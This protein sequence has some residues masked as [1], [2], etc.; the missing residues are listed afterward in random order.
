MTFYYLLRLALYPL[1]CFLCLF[2]KKIRKRFVFERAINQKLG[3]LA[4]GNFDTAFEFSSE[5]E[6]ELVKPL[7]QYSL[8]RGDKIELLFSSDSV[9]GAVEKLQRAYP[10]QIRVL[11]LPIVSFTPFGRSFVKNWVSAKRFVLTRYDFFP[12]IIDCAKNKEFILISGSLKKFIANPSKLKKIYFKWVYSSFDKI[13]MATD[14]EK[15]NVRTLGI[16]H[17]NIKSFDFRPFQIFSRINQ[18]EKNDVLKKVVENLN[19]DKRKKII[20]G[21]FWADE[22][23][24]LQNP[25]PDFFDQFQVCV[26]PHLLDSKSIDECY[27][28]LE[29]IFATEISIFSKDK[30]LQ[31][32]TII[33]YKGILCELYQSFDFSYIAGGFR[34]TV[35]SLLEPFLSGSFVLCGPSVS[36]STEYD[37]ILSIDKNR[38]K[39]INKESFYNS[40]NAVGEDCE[41]VNKFKST[42]DSEYISYIKWV[43]G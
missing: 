39:I 19:Q 42:I 24:F 21:S 15:R 35:H 8:Q 3:P 17:D 20:L 2:N 25:P 14:T 13:L 22:A 18:V 16:E 38:I 9:Y 30:S 40:L 31:N 27:R 34:S 1:I 32:V 5:G 11:C 7:I 6:L 37:M 26:V 10:D 33:D 36:K 12:E 29:N 28:T 41:K 4:K 23:Q 43:L